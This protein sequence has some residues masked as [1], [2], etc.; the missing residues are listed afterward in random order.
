MAWF[1]IRF[2]FAMGPLIFLLAFFYIDKLSIRLKKPAISSLIGLFV[3]TLPIVFVG[4][5]KMSTL[6][7]N[8]KTSEYNFIK[9]LNQFAVNGDA[10]FV[11][12]ANH[13]WIQAM[14]PQSIVYKSHFRAIC[15]DELV[16]NKTSTE[17]WEVSRAFSTSATLDQSIKTFEEYSQGKPYFVYLDTINY[18]C[19]NG[20]LFPA[21]EY[22]ILD[23]QDG[24]IFLKHI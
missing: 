5:K 6:S 1:P 24:Y 20:E 22:T 14:I 4:A 7:A 13:R 9:S 23:Q 12:A 19:I 8:I 2:V 15:S 10:I 17:K 21:S 11:G 16:K 3:I 18:H